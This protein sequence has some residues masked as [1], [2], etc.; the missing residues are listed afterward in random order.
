MSDG[1]VTFVIDS[2]APPADPAELV[3]AVARLLIA[4]DEDRALTRTTKG[5]P[6]R[7]RRYD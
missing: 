6:A 4:M 5:R 7:L 3:E 2:D 1:T